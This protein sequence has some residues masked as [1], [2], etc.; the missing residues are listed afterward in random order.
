MANRNGIFIQWREAD[1]TLVELLASSEG[2]N[3]ADDALKTASHKVSNILVLNTTLLQRMWLTTSLLVLRN[4]FGALLL[5]QHTE[6]LSKLLIQSY[7][8]S[9]L[10]YWVGESY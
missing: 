4:S 3:T 2:F 10:W 6:K 9:N 8:C 7:R 5:N 1:F